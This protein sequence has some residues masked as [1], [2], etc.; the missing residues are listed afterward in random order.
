MFLIQT[1]RPSNHFYDNL[2]IVFLLFPWQ[3]LLGRQCANFSLSKLSLR[4]DFKTLQRLPVAWLQMIDSFSSK[5]NSEKL[6]CEEL[7]DNCQLKPLEICC[8]KLLLRILAP[9]LFK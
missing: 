2:K 1:F 8:V 9:F 3:P 7:P 4:R 6:L 5:S